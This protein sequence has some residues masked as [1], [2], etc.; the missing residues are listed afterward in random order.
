MLPWLWQ[1]PIGSQSKASGVP[2]SSSTF[3]CV[4]APACGA[5]AIA[6]GGGAVIAAAPMVK[7]MLFSVD[8][9][10]GAL[11]GALDRLPVAIPNPAGALRPETP[12]GAAA[13]EPLRAPK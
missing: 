6:G 1:T 11:A 4:R 8:V 7:D 5:N 13:A 2:L 9:V 12:V 10:T 3:P